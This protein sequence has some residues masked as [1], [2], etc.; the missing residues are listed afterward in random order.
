MF[1]QP[2]N[3]G[4]TSPNSKIKEREANI[5]EMKSYVVSNNQRFGQNSESWRQSTLTHKEEILGAA[6]F[7]QK[8]PKSKRQQVDVTTAEDAQNAIDSATGPVELKFE[9]NLTLSSTINV[10]QGKDV[11]IDLNEQT[12][13]ANSETG[14]TVNGGNLTIKNGSITGSQRA[15]IVKGGGTAIVESGDFTTTRVG[16]VMNAQQDNSTLIINGGKF[17]AQESA[18]MAFDGANIVVNGGQFESV[19]NYPFGTNGTRGRGKNTLTLNKC[20]IKGGITS[21]GYEACGIYVANDDVVTVGSQVEIEVKNGCGI[22]IRG[23][24][25]TVKS[26]V[27]INLTTDKP[28]GFGGMV[29]DSEIVMYQSGIIF[30]QTA[31]YPD[32]ANMEL[33]VED[34]VTINAIAHSIEVLSEEENPKVTIGQGQYVPAYPEV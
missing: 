21:N 24:K 4:K 30:H 14:I 29:G 17:H 16:Q 11:V 26:G 8:E 13:T 32:K 7:A 3:S 31:N 2:I 28:E 20:K 18:I 22:L 9:D 27:K 19:D 5:Q 33:T 12:L 23:G 25:V 1:I 10:G 34:G 6:V 15:L